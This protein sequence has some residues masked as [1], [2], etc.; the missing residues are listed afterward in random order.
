MHRRRLDFERTTIFTCILH[1]PFPQK[2]A[3]Q[4]WGA[5]LKQ[6]SCFLLRIE[7]WKGQKMA[8]TSLPPLPQL[9]RRKGR[10]QSLAAVL[11]VT[12]S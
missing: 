5:C 9:H 10:V 2:L 6:G 12:L 7:A 3:F 1:P 11:D 4:N 8:A